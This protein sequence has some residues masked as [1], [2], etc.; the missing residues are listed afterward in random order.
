MEFSKEVFVFR[1][2]VRNNPPMIDMGWT[3][4]PEE[5]AGG[6]CCLVKSFGLGVA[7]PLGVSEGYWWTRMRIAVFLSDALSLIK[8]DFPFCS[9]TK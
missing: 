9:L 4:H 1:F 8:E 5:V 7:L 3:A 6:V 2:L